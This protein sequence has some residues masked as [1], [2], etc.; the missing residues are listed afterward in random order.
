MERRI[1]RMNAGAGLPGQASEPAVKQHTEATR[2]SPA[3]AVSRSDESS[4][5][6]TNFFRAQR[7]F[8]AGKLGLLLE[9][10]PMALGWATVP[11]IET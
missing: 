3:K 5:A 11:R 1:D 10:F 9:F 7:G 6:V 8:L 2:Q 4:A